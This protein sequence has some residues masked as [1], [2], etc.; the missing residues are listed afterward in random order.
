MICMIFNVLEFLLVKC[1]ARKNFL[2]S[3]CE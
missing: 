1:L 2:Y 3:F